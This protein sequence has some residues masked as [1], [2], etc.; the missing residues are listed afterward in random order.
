MI[1]SGF[2]EGCH[3]ALR[4]RARSSSQ[5]ARL[6][7]QQF[8]PGHAQQRAPQRSARFHCRDPR[9]LQPRPCRASD[10]RSRLPGFSAAWPS[11][12]SQPRQATGTRG[13]ADGSEG[14]QSSTSAR[15]GSFQ[16]RRRRAACTPGR[17][18]QPRLPS[19]RPERRERGDV[20]DL[21]SRSAD[22]SRF[23]TVV[24]GHKVP[25][26]S[27][28][29]RRSTSPHLVAAALPAGDGWDGAAFS[30]PEPPAAGSAGT[31]RLP[32]TAE[33]AFESASG[34]QWRRWG[35]GASRPAP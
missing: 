3:V 29:L 25:P 33:G 10:S 15:R 35:A 24:S 6:G 12:P 22:C 28:Q 2:A 21:G 14:P 16:H 18:G 13:R 20:D 4:R 5:K 34:A 31:A 32:R 1:G 23:G 19:P 11:S 8:P 27:A 7:F 26:R 9:R 17:G 30:S